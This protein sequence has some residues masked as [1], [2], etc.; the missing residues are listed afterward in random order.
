MQDQDMQVS[1]ELFPPKTEAGIARLEGTVDDLARAAPDYFSVTYGAGGTTRQTT[2]RVVDMVRA[3]GGRPVA[4][5][6]TCVGANRAEIEAQA[7]ALWDDGIRKIVALR[8]DLPEG[9]SLPADGFKNAA[10][11]VE[12][13]RRVADFDIAVAAYPEPH[14]DSRGEEADLDY[15]KRKIDAGASCA[16]TQFV[17][18]TDT[19]LRFVDRARAA[20]VEAPIIP[21]IMPVHNFA[22]LKRFSAGCGAS[23]PG[24]ME[25]MFAGLD[26]NPALRGMVATSVAVEQCRRLMDAGLDRFHIYT[27]NKADVTLAICRA[28]GLPVD[29]PAQAAA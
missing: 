13:L 18:D 10:E 16:I 8:G 9:Q 4:Q 24:W 20:G 5:H 6:L 29:L 15:L 17:F 7:K 26:D 11:L 2:H 12:A 23:I 27:L 22:T 21:G 14:P 28:L 1:F 3:R 19:V 25:E